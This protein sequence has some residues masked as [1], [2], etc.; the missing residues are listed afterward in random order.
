MPTFRRRCAMAANSILVA[1][2]QYYQ[3]VG[4]CQSTQILKIGGLGL[5]VYFAVGQAKL[6]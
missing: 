1:R 6:R 5:T 2:D 3:P 4:E